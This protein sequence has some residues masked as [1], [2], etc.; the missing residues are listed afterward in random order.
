MKQLIE[1]LSKYGGNPK[2]ET[3]SLRLSM[4]LGEAFRTIDLQ[5]SEYFSNCVPALTLS[6]RC[7]RILSPHHILEENQDLIPGCY[8]SICGLLVI[9]TDDSGN[10]ISVDVENGRVYQFSHDK[11]ESDGLHRGWNEGVTDF[12]PALPFTR[13]NIILIAEKEWD[14]VTEFIESLILFYSREPSH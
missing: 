2:F 10:A 7:H 4:L 1:R 5:V 11:F 13:E 12:L 14:S 6:L 8:C 3:T 9:A